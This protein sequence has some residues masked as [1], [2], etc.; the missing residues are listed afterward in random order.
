MGTL[1]MYELF[2]KLSH[3]LIFLHVSTAYV[4]SD[5]FGFIEEKIYTKNIEPI[6]LLNEI[7]D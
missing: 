5:M 6:S 7:K 3:P 2:S 1:R 4:N